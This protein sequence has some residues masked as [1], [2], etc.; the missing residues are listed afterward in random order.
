[1]RIGID[2]RL[3]SQSGVGR[4]IRN[5]LSNL[6]KLDNKNDYFIFHLM[7]DSKKLV[8]HNNFKKIVADFR[9][10]S[11]V[12]QIKFPPLLN[13]YNLDLVHFPHFNVPF[14]YK[15]K[16]V[17]TI[18]DLIH[19]HFAM[20]RATAH[21]P[22]IFRIKQFGYKKVFSHAVLKSE[23]IIAVSNFIKS[24]LISEWNISKERIEVT[25]E[26]VA[27]QILTAM[28]KWN[29]SK[30]QTVLNRFNIRPPF[31]FYIGNAHPHKNVEGLIKAFQELKKKNNNLQLVLSG[32][33]HYFWQR[34]KKEFKNNGIIYTGSINDEEL[35]ALY[36]S[37]KTFVMPS[38]EEGFGIPILEA[39]ACSCPVISSNAG[40][41]TEVGG[42]ACLY[43]DPK[44]QEDMVD[45]ISQPLH[46]ENLVK[47]LIEKGK[48]RVKQFSFEKLAKKTLEIY[49]SV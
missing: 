32:S 37:A 46:D 35:V 26:A 23:K 45:K 8:Y 36:K 34:I 9:W 20:K 40:S 47:K 15:G 39:F 4:Y 19:Q 42:D 3:Y 31:I 48:K 14:F 2:A 18:H 17:V 12:E 38:F 30:S 49:N 24:Q 13:K 11:L 16:F 33:D 7:K 10:Y 41:L 5:L 21:D 44:N 43:F 1:M 6:Q 22:I 29:L 27:D 28:K 25:P